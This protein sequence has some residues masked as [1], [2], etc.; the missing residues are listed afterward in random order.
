M[1]GVSSDGL[2]TTEWLWSLSSEHHYGEP[3]VTFGTRL[4]ADLGF[5]PLYLRPK[6]ITR[7]VAILGDIMSTRAWDDPEFRTRNAVT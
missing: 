2:S 5:T 4:E 7:A 1:S 6:D 3:G